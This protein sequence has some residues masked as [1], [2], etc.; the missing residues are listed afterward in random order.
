MFARPQYGQN[1]GTVGEQDWKAIGASQLQVPVAP[2]SW[3]DEPHGTVQCRVS[4][5]E[6]VLIFS[7]PRQK[8]P[9]IATN[10]ARHGFLEEPAPVATEASGTLVGPGQAVSATARG[11]RI[12]TPLMEGP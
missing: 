12:R 2:Q 6:S 1:S 10:R 3:T 7:K 8:P 9:R 4:W 5:S 11:K